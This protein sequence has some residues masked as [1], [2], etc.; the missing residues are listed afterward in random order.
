MILC[1]K[2]QD[3]MNR[4]NQPRKRP[5]FQAGFTLIELMAVMAIIATMTALGASY[6]KRPQEGQGL[7]LSLSTTSA[8]FQSARSLALTMNT[9]T[10][11][12]IHDDPGDSRRYGREIIVIYRDLDPNG[13]P[14]WHV[15]GRPTNLPQGI[16]YDKVR[17]T[18]TGSDSGDPLV[19]SVAPVSMNFNFPGDLAEGSGPKWLAYEFSSN[20]TCVQAGEPFFL[21][22]ARSDT[23]GLVTSKENFSGFVLR[24]MGNVTFL[25]QSK[26]LAD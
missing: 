8:L 4:V 3:I 10:K 5:G 26:T 17:S 2:V 14:A 21:T 12:L 16:Y 19:S 6:L 7:N 15:Q 22:S 24:R 25:P 23:G 13:Q 1:I 20:G 18:N 9:P 11:L